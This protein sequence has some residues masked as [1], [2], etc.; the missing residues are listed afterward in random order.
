MKIQDTVEIK[1]AASPEG[2][3]ERGGFRF[4]RYESANALTILAMVLRGREI[5]ARQAAIFESYEFSAV[6]IA[7]VKAS[8]QAAQ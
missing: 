1:I 2:E 3:F 6:E 5:T 7:N 8:V 4:V